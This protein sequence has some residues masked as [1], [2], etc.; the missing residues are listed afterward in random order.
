MI[1]LPVRLNTLSVKLVTATALFML[2][3]LVTVASAVG[4]GLRQLQTD[5]VELSAGALSHQGEAH[6]AEMVTLEATRSDDMFNRAADLT[7]TAAEFLSIAHARGLHTE[8]APDLQ[9]H[10]GQDLRFDANPN[11]ITD[12]VIPTYTPL[13]A[14]QHSRLRESAL[15]DTILPALYAQFPGAVAIYY[16]EASMAF[17]YYPAIGIADYL[18]GTPG[19]APDRRHYMSEQAPAGPINNPSRATVWDAPY[20]DNA[21]QGLMVTVNTP[22]YFGDDYAG[23]VSMDIS[24][25]ALV[26]RLQAMQP[27]AHS[28]AFL[29]DGRSA[30]VAASPAAIGALVGGESKQET[31]LDAILGV[32]VADNADLAPVLPSMERGES[33]D[34]DLVLGGQAMRLSYAPLPTL[35]WTLAVAAP[36]AELTASARAV[37]DQTETNAAR[38]LRTS[39]ALIAL[40]FLTALAAVFLTNRALTR[41]VTDLMRGAE[42]VASGDLDIT[43]THTSRDELGRLALSFNHMTGAL[44]ASRQSLEAQNQALRMEMSERAQAE[45][46]LRTVEERNRLALERNVDERTRELTTLLHLSHRLATTFDLDSLLAVVLDALADVIQHNAVAIFLLDEDDLVLAKYSGPATPDQL[47]ERWPTTAAR[48]IHPVLYE[49]KPLIINDVRAETEDAI[50]YSAFVGSR[51]GATPDYVGAWMAVPLVIKDEVIGMLSFDAAMPNTFNPR[52]ADLALAFANQPP[53]P[54]KMLACTADPNMPL[55]SKKG[56]AWRA[57]C[58]IRCRRRSTASPSAQG[59]RA[60]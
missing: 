20:V 38:I 59:Q 48:H 24:L 13:D 6:L 58:T 50:R 18:T 44:R 47:V 35:G 4:L 30:L 60:H 5:A 39:I 12:L 34:A 11:R 53:S 37:A 2:L 57:N 16:Q 3:L 52:D 36:A 49:R 22:V 21:G 14:A 51:V 40:F 7:R 15:L 56:S 27:T 54:S 19:L 46:A 42:A 33:G 9:L 1:R 23:I 43:L 8:D 10:P 41:P 17:R 55:S 31:Q 29:V 25:A 28:F 32:S 26:D 45:H